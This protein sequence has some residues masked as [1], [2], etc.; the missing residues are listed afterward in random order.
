MWNC[1]HITI[2]LL[3]GSEW[4][5]SR[6]WGRTSCTLWMGGITSSLEDVKK[7]KRSCSY[8]ESNPGSPASGPSLNRLIYFG[9]PCLHRQ[10]KRRGNF[11]FHP[12][13]PWSS[14]NTDARYSSVFRTFFLGVRLLNSA[15][16]TQYR[17]SQK[18]CCPL[19]K[20]RRHLEATAV[21]VVTIFHTWKRFSS[22][23][24]FHL[25]IVFVMW[26]AISMAIDR[27][28]LLFIHI[29]QALV[30]SSRLK[31]LFCVS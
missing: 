21:P 15:A 5:A 11:T 3:D 22:Y 29:L 13:Q 10:I 28:M 18:G 26:R 31:F 17:K 20:N 25:F 4:L 6:P 14:W 12:L 23:I 16:K 19:A 24:F 7:R 8:R 27:L 1:R 9:S 30:F 2:I